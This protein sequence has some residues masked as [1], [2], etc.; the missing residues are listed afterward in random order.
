[1]ENFGSEVLREDSTIDRGKLGT[2]VFDD[3]DKLEKLNRCVHPLIF[4]EWERQ[5][6]DIGKKRPDAIIISDMPL[7]VETG[8]MGDVDL[9]VLVYISREEQIQRLIKRNGYSRSEALARLDSQMPIDDKLAYCDFVINNGGSIE[10]TKKQVDNIWIE[11]LERERL[12]RMK[13]S[14]IL[15]G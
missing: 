13:S 11:L 14:K 10:E 6:V 5:I 1:M 2:I 4:E 3:R 12:I 15:E 8:K 9:V 7:L